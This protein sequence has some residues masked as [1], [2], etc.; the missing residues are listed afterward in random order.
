MLFLSDDSNACAVRTQCFLYGA[1][2]GKTNSPKYAALLSN[3]HSSMA[4]LRLREAI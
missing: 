1:P 3:P 2:P 4:D